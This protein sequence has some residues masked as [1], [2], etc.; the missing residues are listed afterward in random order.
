MPG[1]LMQMVAYGCGDCCNLME[2]S[3]NLHNHVLKLYYEYIEENQFSE[4]VTINLNDPDAKVSMEENQ[5][6]EPITIN[7]NN[8]DE[9][10]S[11]NLYSTYAHKYYKK[12]HVSANYNK[13]HITRYHKKYERDKY[14]KHQKSRKYR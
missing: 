11:T 10:V 13:R 6:S 12:T 9:K 8:P 14:N 3:N 1:G 5:Y 4:P 7:L 2:Y